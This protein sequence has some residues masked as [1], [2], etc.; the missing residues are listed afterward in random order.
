MQNVQRK[1]ET[2]RPS[3]TQLRNFPRNKCRVWGPNEF[4]KQRFGTHLASDQSRRAKCSA[5]RDRVLVFVCFVV[6]AIA[7]LTTCRGD[8]PG[9]SSLGPGGELLAV[10]PAPRFLFASACLT[11]PHFWGIYCRCWACSPLKS[12]KFIDNLVLLFNFVSFS[13]WSCRLM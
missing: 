3:Q 4:E 11:C 9:A 1:V 5:N 7:F 12:Q 6:S 2:R 13:T 10:H 8:A